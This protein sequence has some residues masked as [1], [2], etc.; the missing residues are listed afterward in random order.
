M[1][2]VM[3]WSRWRRSKVSITPSAAALSRLPVGSSA[4]RMRGRWARARAID[5]RCCC[6]PDS[7]VGRRDPSSPRPSWVSTARARAAA[8]ARVMSR[9]RSIGTI[10]FSS[11][12]NSG[13]RKWNWKTKP[14]RSPRRA[15]RST[16]SRPPSDTPSIRTS[17]AVGR[18]SAA[19][20]YSRVDLPEPLGPVTLT[21]S[22]A[23]MVRSMPCR[24]RVLTSS[25][26]S[27]TSARASSAGAVAAGAVTS[28]SARRPARGATPARPGP[29][30]PAGRPPP[31]TRTPAR[32]RSAARRWRT[33]SG[34]RSPCP[35][36]S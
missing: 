30:W 4:N 29:G 22:P 18:S 21:N 3:P 24:M 25:P 2:M 33:C 27:R 12:V 16:S 13:R 34:G 31:R 32:T 28:P 11:T 15:P 36:R 1:T 5:T 10:T 7:W 20:R 23:A 9:R 14:S 19:R 35:T 8:S 6:P 26:R 17:P